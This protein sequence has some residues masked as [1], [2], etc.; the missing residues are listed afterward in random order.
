MR[1]NPPSASTSTGLS[2][3]I[4]RIHS[5]PILGAEVERELCSRWRDHHDVSAAH[6]L[7]NCHLPLVVQ[8]AR[9][10]RGYGLQWEELL[11]EGHVG[12]M[13][14]LCRF[15]PDHGVRFTTYA[16]WW[17]RASIQQYVLHN[18]PLTIMDT[19]AA[20][21]TLFFNLRRMRANLQEFD[22]GAPKVEHVS[23]V[24]RTLRASKH[25]VIG[26]VQR[27]A[28]P[29]RSLNVPLDADSQRPRH[30]CDDCRNS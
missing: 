22:N 27:M 12:L 8:I 17:V 6:A 15:D 11:G 4:R 29:D 20:Q 9:A 18:W 16:T 19:T 26:M 5:F 13:R 21:T 1:K 3:Y 28:G 10:Y 25:D 7:A 2:W 23:S 30:Q 14:A 24:A